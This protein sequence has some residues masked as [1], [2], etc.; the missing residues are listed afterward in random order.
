ME[1]TE[2]LDNGEMDDAL[3]FKLA[4]ERAKH[5]IDCQGCQYSVQWKRLARLGQLWSEEHDW[6]SRTIEALSEHAKETGR[7]FVY[8]TPEYG[9]FVW[10]AML[11]FQKSRIIKIR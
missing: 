9:R 2:H 3:D 6:A 8:V 10:R 1:T 11:P 7:A 5:L 4:D